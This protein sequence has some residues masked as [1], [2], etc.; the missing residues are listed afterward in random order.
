MKIYFQLNLRIAEVP[1]CEIVLPVERSSLKWKSPNIF[2]SYFGAYRI[3]HHIEI[4]LQGEYKP[5]PSIQ[6]SSRKKIMV[7]PGVLKFTSN[8]GIKS[9]HLLKNALYNT[10][11][12]R[13]VL[14]KLVSG[15]IATSFPRVPL[16]LI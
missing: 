10:K 9:R 14:F 13:V 1:A 5:L 15:T 6:N 16:P 12:V 2:N 3:V 7:L 11:H 8:L 4:P